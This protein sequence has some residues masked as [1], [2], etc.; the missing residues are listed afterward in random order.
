MSMKDVIPHVFLP[1]DIPAEEQGNLIQVE[2]SLLDIL[3]YIF[4]WSIRDTDE[5]ISCMREICPKT[6]KLLQR[7]VVGQR[8][9]SS[10]NVSELIPREMEAGDMC[11]FY[12]RSQNCGL[13]L[14]APSSENENRL[15]L[16]SFKASLGSSEVMSCIGDRA[17]VVPQQS[18]WISK[19]EL[20]HSNEFATQLCI[21]SK[22]SVDS[23]VPEMYKAGNRFPNVRDVPYPHLITDLVTLALCDGFSEVSNAF[24]Q[25]KKTIRD[26]VRWGNC[27]VPFRRSGLWFTA[28]AALQVSLIREHGEIEGVILYKTFMIQVLSFVLKCHH[29]VS[30]KEKETVMEILPSI[31]RRIEKLQKLLKTTT[32]LKTGTSNFIKFIVDT[33]ICNLK[34]IHAVV[35]EEWSRYSLSQLSDVV[36]VS[37][38]SSQL[39]LDL[40]HQLDELMKELDLEDLRTF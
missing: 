10:P 26:D 14:S 24:P 9:L 6:S 20:L 2:Q 1:R 19:T 33:T 32:N 22:N 3:E 23:M 18:I 7:W 39:Q 4:T 15:I 28:K 36:K 13:F 21:L 37:L 27:L 12:I 8:I 5:G 16:S 31:T 35:S 11:A 25:I 34:K 40:K 29:D 30:P 17:V 38:P